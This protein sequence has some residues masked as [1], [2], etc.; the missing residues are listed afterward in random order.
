VRRLFG[1]LDHRPKQ[2]PAIDTGDPAS[3]FDL[4]PLPNGARINLGVYGNTPAASLSVP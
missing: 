2:S 4:E 1:N 3:P